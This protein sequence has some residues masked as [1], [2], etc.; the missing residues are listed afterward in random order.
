[1]RRF[2]PESLIFIQACRIIHVPGKKILG[3]DSVSSPAED[4]E[5][6]EMNSYISI[7][8][9]LARIRAV[10][11]PNEF[12][13][14]IKDLPIQLQ[15]YWRFKEGLAVMDGVFTYE[16]QAAVPPSLCREISDHLHAP[17]QGKTQ[18]FSRQQYSGP[19]RITNDLTD[20]AQM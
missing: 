1:M 10:E 7:I 3:P 9:C 12:P 13:P 20:E 14:E 2:Q 6:D 17:Y 5:L 18:M 19:A 8:D 16:G 11:E 15:Q 4:P